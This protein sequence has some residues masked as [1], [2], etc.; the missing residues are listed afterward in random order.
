M[1][2]KHQRRPS[3]MYAKYSYY[4]KNFSENTLKLK[5]KKQ[6]QFQYIHF[7]PDFQCGAIYVALHRSYLP[8]RCAVILPYYLPFLQ[9]GHLSS[10]YCVLHL[11]AQRSAQAI[12][13]NSCM[14]S[15]PSFLSSIC[16]L[17]MTRMLNCI[18][19]RF[20]TLRVPIPPGVWMCACCLCRVVTGGTSISY[21]SFYFL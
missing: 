8:S 20:V 3:H 15:T 14:Q 16:S 13:S 21:F 5:N 11:P 9:C 10:P 12:S 4:E 17:S 1:A 18:Y 6:F 19:A 7:G 2:Q